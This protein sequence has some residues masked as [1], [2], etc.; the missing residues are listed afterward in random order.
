MITSGNVVFD[1]QYM[2][3]IFYISNHSVNVKNGDVMMSII[4]TR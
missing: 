1:A 2:I 3:S 4:S